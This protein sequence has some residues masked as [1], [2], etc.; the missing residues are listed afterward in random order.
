[1][2]ERVSLKFCASFMQQLVS[3]WKTPNPRVCGENVKDQVLS[4]V[5]SPTAWVYVSF[6]KI[7]LRITLFG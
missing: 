1:M 5:L 7:V 6:V 2:A 3:F 4:P